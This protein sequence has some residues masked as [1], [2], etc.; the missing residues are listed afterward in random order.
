MCHAYLITF[1]TYGSWLHGAERGSVDRHH[2]QYGAP[3]R[4]ANA[5]LEQ[6]VK[7]RLKHDPVN[8]N[9]AQRKVVREAIVEVCE[10]R[11]WQLK[12]VHVRTNHVH[13]VVVS[14]ATAEKVMNDFKTYA[15]RRLR[16]AGLCA[17]SSKIWSRHGSTPHL[18]TEEAVESACRYVVDGQGAALPEE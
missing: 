2:N 3:L 4:P 11:Q 10:F 15:T 1:H 9:A 14:N 13:A 17:A 12:A 16:E 8:L 18:L 6:A 5:E 7:Q